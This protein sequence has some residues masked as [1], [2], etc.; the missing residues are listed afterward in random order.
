MFDG[1][2]L[3]R[4]PSLQLRRLRRQFQVVF[5]DPYSALDPR[6]LVAEILE[7][8]LRALGVGGN[9]EARQARIDTLLAQVGLPTEAKRRYP[10]E[11]SGGQ[12][13]RINI[14]RAL[15]VEPKLIICD[16]PTSSLDVSVQAQILNLLKQLQDTLGLAYLFITHN[17]SVVAYLAHEVAVMYLGRIVESGRTEEVLESP[18]H[19]Y[20]RA[21]L[22]AVPR[23]EPGSE[24]RVIRLEGDIPSPSAPPTG[25][26]FHP[27]CPEAMPVCRQAYPES[28][29]V[30]GT[31][32]V[33]CYLY[34]PRAS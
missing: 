34:S 17:L 24:R 31:H 13:Q 11:F 1:H 5:Q 15:A 16:E 28:S 12:R 21:L 25:C 8:G 2:E 6:M 9:Q 23:I 27:R 22:A 30:T 29:R 18:K 7:E 14:A 20:T 10:H 3:T 4:L 32:E 19:P 33:R 26:H